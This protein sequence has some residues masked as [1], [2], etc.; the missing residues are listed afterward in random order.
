[1]L[2]RLRGDAVATP[3]AVLTIY[4]LGLTALTFIINLLLSLTKPLTFDDEAE[5]FWRGESLV[6][7]VLVAAGVVI[8]RVA[9]RRQ[10]CATMWKS[11]FED[12]LK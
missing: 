7:G 8:Y 1:M 4:A 5:H 3:A 10:R 6:V 12:A 2:S 11:A 9:A